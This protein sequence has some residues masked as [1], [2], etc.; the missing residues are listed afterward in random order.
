MKYNGP[1]AK[2]CRRQ[3]M[4]LYGTDKYDK[5]LQRKPS[6]PGRNPKS[7]VPKLSEFG[8][9]L[10]EKQKARDMYGLSESQFR[11]LYEQATKVKGQT[12]NA[13]KQLLER[14]LD[15]VI[16]RSGLAMTR[17]QSRQF[18][19]HGLFLVDDVRVTTPSFQVKPGMVISIRPRSKNS[20]VFGPI[21]DAHKK[22]T[23]PAWLKMDS[24]GMKVEVVNL[25]EPEAAEQAIDT[26]QIIE[27][28]SR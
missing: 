10:K 13:L 4:N 27:F 18:V 3:G 8:Q 14:R 9:Q 23:L 5:I 6:G 25:P 2:R 12:G 20:A 24:S 21:Q 16:Y 22:Y 11:R 1:K 17:L 26:R 28:Y 7:Q 15:N 19:G